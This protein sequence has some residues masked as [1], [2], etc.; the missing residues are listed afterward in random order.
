[1]SDAWTAV[2]WEELGLGSSLFISQIL[3]FEA[4]DAAIE[5]EPT[6]K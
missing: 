3:K 2:D 5:V 4:P 6:S 1:M